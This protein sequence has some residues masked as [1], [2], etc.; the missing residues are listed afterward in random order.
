MKSFKIYF[1]RFLLALS[2]FSTLGLLNCASEPEIL[3][4]TESE[5]IKPAVHND[6]KNDSKIF[7]K[8]NDFEK[9]AQEEDQRFDL[10]VVSTK[11]LLGIQN[12]KIGVGMPG[13]IKEKKE[14]I[15]G[16]EKISNPALNAGKRF[17]N[18]MW[19]VDRGAREAGYAGVPGMTLL[20]DITTYNSTL[21]SAIYTT[22]SLQLSAVKGNVSG[23]KKFFSGIKYKTIGLSKSEKNALLANLKE[24]TTSLDESKERIKELTDFSAKLEG[25]LKDAQKQAGADISLIT[26]Y[27]KNRFLE[28]STDVEIISQMATSLLLIGDLIIKSLQ[29]YKEEGDIGRAMDGFRQNTRF[30]NGLP[31]FSTHIKNKITELFQ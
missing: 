7:E 24:I 29:P 1:Y 26:I 21:Y 6:S 5:T 23:I 2:F 25:L 31:A 15:T 8:F 14:E 18:L 19:Y 9:L 22:K 17:T 12:E 30:V 13:P 28:F 16:I 4:P 11:S 3:P 10:W 20:A 27:S